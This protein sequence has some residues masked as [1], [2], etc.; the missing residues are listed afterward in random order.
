MPSESS[1]ERPIPLSEIV[2]EKINPVRA[3]IISTAFNPML[4]QA[5]YKIADDKRDEFKEKILNST[6]GSIDFKPVVEKSTNSRRDYWR[7]KDFDEQNMEWNEATWKVVQN[8]VKPDNPELEDVKKAFGSIGL[9][10]D[11][12]SQ[13]GTGLN[14]QAEQFRAKYFEGDS[15]VKE[16][17]SDIAEGCIEDGSVNT[18]LVEKRLR[19]ID[20]LLGTFGKTDVTELAKDYAISYSLLAQQ[21][22]VKEIVAETVFSYVSAPNPQP[23][24]ETPTER[25]RPGFLGFLE[26][27]IPFAGLA[28]LVHLTR[29]KESRSTV[30]GSTGREYGGDVPESDSGYESQAA[31]PSYGYSDN[32]SEGGDNNGATDSY[33]SDRGYIDIGAS[34]YGDQPDA[35]TSSTGGFEGYSD[36]GTPDYGDSG[37]AT[38][39]GGFSGYTDIGDRDYGDN[40][41]GTETGGFSG[42]TDI[43]EGDY[44][45]GE[46]ATETGGFAGYPDI[47]E[48]D[49]GSDEDSGNGDGNGG[50]GDGG[51]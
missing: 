44:G 22:E 8:M 19:A 33:A 4:Y 51:D 28:G 27:L 26:G 12:T 23:L 3:R 42:Y 11:D 6:P 7:D 2:R 48:P 21:R 13:T 30:E 40:P 47:G 50:D 32:D 1:A 15:K 45:S 24:P 38:G 20:R 25:K 18:G 39:T 46:R 31:T 41:Q 5:E 14:A 29:P 37:R 9:N 49:R 16:F 34:D 36:V 43:G 35:P 17:V 10:P